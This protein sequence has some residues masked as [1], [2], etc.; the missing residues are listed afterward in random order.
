M[1]M[2]E[3]DGGGGDGIISSSI[4]TLFSSINEADG[5]IEATSNEEEFLLRFSI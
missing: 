1:M 3:R 2:M 4:A 5:D